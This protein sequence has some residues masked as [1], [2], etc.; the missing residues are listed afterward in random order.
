MDVV[1]FESD[2]A[3]ARGRVAGDQ[4]GQRALAG[5]RPADHGGQRS[6]TR[7]QRD[8]VQ[9]LFAV[10]DDVL[11][12]AYF[13]TAGACFGF[14]AGN[15]HAAA[16]DQVDV[17]D[18]DDVAFAQ[19]RRTDPGAVDERPVAAAVL[20]LGAQRRKH[21]RRVVAGGQHVGNDDVVVVGAA[22][23]DRTGHFRGRRRTLRQ[24]LHKPRRK[25]GHVAGPRSNDGH[26]GG[27][28]HFRPWRTT[29]VDHRD[30]GGRRTRWRRHMHVGRMVTRRLPRRVA[31]V[32]SWLLPRR[33]RAGRPGPASSRAADLARW[34][35]TGRRCGRGRR[36]PRD[37]GRLG[38]T[39]RPGSRRPS[40]PCALLS[41]LEAQ[42]R[43]AGISDVDALAVMDVDHRPA[44]AVDEGPVD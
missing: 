26:L 4:P 24:E 31:R 19:D 37:G 29:R 14:A 33:G 38:G 3:G 44:V 22:D 17:P 2:R 10:V 9:Q 41:D 12:G 39:L 42:L 6:W 36:R 23:G 25:I 16:D 32:G 13:Q 11:D 34:M 7:G 28:H 1:A 30:V 5:T 27:R 15:Q 18:G 21:Q 35:R 40:R 20:D 8:V 43:S